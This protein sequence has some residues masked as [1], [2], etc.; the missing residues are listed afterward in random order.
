MPSR[1]VTFDHHCSFCK[2][3]IHVICGTTD[4]NDVTVC[5]QCLKARLGSSNE[6][7][8]EGE[9]IGHSNDSRGRRKKSMD[10]SEAD[11][12]AKQHP[13]PSSST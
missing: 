1:V 5:P 11:A 3:F 7:E 12:N 8:K 4:D 2:G 10:E 6:K 13:A 9:T